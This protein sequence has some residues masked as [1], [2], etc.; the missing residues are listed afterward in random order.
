MGVL[1]LAALFEHGEYKR[2]GMAPFVRIATS[3]RKL[4]MDYIVADVRPPLNASV[5][6]PLRC[7]VVPS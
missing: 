7:Q 5:R 6:R 1:W 4:G 3:M 2:A